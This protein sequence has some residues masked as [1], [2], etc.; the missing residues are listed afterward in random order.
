MKMTAVRWSRLDQV[1]RPVGA[2]VIVALVDSIL[3]RF[4]ITYRV[5][6]TPSGD[7]AVVYLPESLGDGP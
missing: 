7:G 5:T 6:R 3:D 4:G 2:R 1:A